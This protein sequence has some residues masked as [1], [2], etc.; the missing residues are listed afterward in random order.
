[1]F[2]SVALMLTLRVHLDV[3]CLQSCKVHGGDGFAFVLQL[4]PNVTS[5]LGQGGEGMGY[6]GIRNALVVEFDTWYNPEQGDL[7]TDHVRWV[8]LDTVVCACV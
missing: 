1:M 3:R 6:A 5:T 7:F 8:D 4:D 2:I